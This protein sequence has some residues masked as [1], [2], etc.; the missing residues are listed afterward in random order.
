M[1]GK[2]KMNKNRILTAVMA[3]TML[4]GSTMP[5]F[6]AATEP[7]TVSQADVGDAGTTRP[8]EVLYT[9]SSSFSVAIPKTIVLDAES[10]ASDYNL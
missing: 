8:T 10:K 6:A 1:K 9:Q 4:M 5:V 7:Q 2:N 3:G